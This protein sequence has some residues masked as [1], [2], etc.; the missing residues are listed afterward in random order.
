MVTF[1]SVATCISRPMITNS[2]VPMPNAPAVNAYSATGMRREEG[3]VA[4]EEGTSGEARSLPLPVTA[5]NGEYGESL[6]TDY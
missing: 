5:R 6:S 4:M 3:A 1:R 2:V